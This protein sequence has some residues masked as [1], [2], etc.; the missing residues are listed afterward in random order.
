[1][2][3]PNYVEM[4]W[5]LW[6]SIC[7]HPPFVY[8][9][10]QFDTYFQDGGLGVGYGH[11]RFPLKPFFTADLEVGRLSDDNFLR[12][13]SFPYNPDTP[14]ELKGLIWMEDNHAAPEVLVTMHNYAW[15][16]NPYSTPGVV[17]VGL[18]RYNWSHDNTAWGKAFHGFANLND[19][20]N[21]I[22]L[23]PTGKWVVLM[24][25]GALTVNYRFIYVVQP[26]DNFVDANMAP[27]DVEPGDLMRV[28]WNDLENPYNNCREG[29][30]EVSYYYRMRKVA[31]VNPDGATVTFDPVHK[32]RL[33]QKATQTVQDV[34]ATD[35]VLPSR[36]LAFHV[37]T[38]L[39]FRRRYMGYYEVSRDTA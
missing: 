4:N 9:P 20:I 33:V 28:S 23:H 14:A 24:S 25:Y 27:L 34:Q 15:K 18:T 31:R 7:P 38:R 11:H 21:A 8:N 5:T 3:Y 10:P 39:I 29:I 35:P 6:D 22:Q 13:I 2:Y 19:G 1:M 32:P 17:G 36:C 30:D 26:G 12:E 37:A 16:S